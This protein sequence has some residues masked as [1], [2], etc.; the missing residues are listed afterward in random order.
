MSDQLPAVLPSG[1]IA[2]AASADTYEE[3]AKG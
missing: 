3:E 2:P 1:A